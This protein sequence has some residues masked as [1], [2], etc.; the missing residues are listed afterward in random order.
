MAKSEVE[1]RADQW[2]H[3]LHDLHG[4]LTEITQDYQ[5]ML[6]SG[7]EQLRETT[8]QTGESVAETVRVVRTATRPWWIPVGVLALVIVVVM[9]A[10]NRWLASSGS[11][12]TGA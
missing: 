11:R 8:D 7:K 6:K 12:E 1:K 9:L 10:T 3:Q 2:E 5:A 4:R